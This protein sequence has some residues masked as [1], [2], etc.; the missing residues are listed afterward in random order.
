MSAKT[1]RYTIDLSS[2]DHK[3]IRTMASLLG[4]SMKDLFL[5]SI[6]EFTQKKFNKNTQKALK[7]AVTKKNL[8]KFESINDMFKDLGI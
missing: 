5:L 8:K 1:I 6:E 2:N 4:L 7:E 3:K